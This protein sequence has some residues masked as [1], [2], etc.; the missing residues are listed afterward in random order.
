MIFGLQL[1]SLLLGIT[2]PFIPF[3]NLFCAIFFGGV[4]DSMQRAVGGGPK[5]ADAAAKSESK[6]SKSDDNSAAHA[7]KKSD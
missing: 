7:T 6:A 4:W 2:D 1:S 3:E 5:N